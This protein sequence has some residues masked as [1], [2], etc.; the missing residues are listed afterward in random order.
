MIIKLKRNC[1]VHIHDSIKQLTADRYRE[2]QNYIAQEA[3][4]GSD[5]SGIK[6]R[7]EDVLRYLDTDIETTRNVAVN[8]Y[9]AMQAIEGKV[10]YGQRS[11]AILIKK[12][13]YN[14]GTEYI[15][16]DYSDDELDYMISELSEYGLTQETVEEANQDVKKN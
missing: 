15:P 11:F 16:S 12:I 6:K 14:N 8:G 10:N 2:F 13:Q 9:F 3:E 5:L 4:I 7:F 1:R